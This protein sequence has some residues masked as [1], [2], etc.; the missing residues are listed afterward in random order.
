VDYKSLQGYSL[1]LR[2]TQT[3]LNTIFL[4]QIQL[5]TIIGIMLGD[6]HIKK[7]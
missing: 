6:F 1:G 4:T 3:S 2:L 5:E 7:K